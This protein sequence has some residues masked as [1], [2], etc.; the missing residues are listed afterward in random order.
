MRAKC[1]FVDHNAR[2]EPDEPQIGIMVAG[3]GSSNTFWYVTG[4]TVYIILFL[5]HT[6]IE[7]M[8]SYDC[9]PCFAQPYHI[10]QVAD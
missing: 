4:N 5:F 3:H 1:H 2:T 10:S 8:K 6:A 7:V 9:I